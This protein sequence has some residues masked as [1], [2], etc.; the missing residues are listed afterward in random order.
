M[1][2]LNKSACN[3]IGDDGESKDSFIKGFKKK[4]R[5]KYLKQ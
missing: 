3:V 2:L 1:F 4:E 5:K